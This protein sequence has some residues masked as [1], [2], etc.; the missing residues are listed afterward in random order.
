MGALTQVVAGSVFATEM[1]TPN[2]P[3]PGA[4][5]EAVRYVKG[6]PSPTKDE[7]AQWHDAESSPS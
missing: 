4:R 1:A 5:I 2:D 3:P 7:E 6:D